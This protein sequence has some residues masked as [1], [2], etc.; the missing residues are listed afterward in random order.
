VTCA[1]LP[2]RVSRIGEHRRWAAKV[3]KGARV[4]TGDSRQSVDRAPH[5]SISS[6]PPPPPSLFLSL[7]RARARSFF[8][9]SVCSACSSSRHREAEH[10][11]LTK[12]ARGASVWACGEVRE[13][14]PVSARCLNV[15]KPRRAANNRL[16]RLRLRADGLDVAGTRGLS[17]RARSRSYGRVLWSR[18]YV[19]GLLWPW[20][21]RARER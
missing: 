16:I 15:D 19:R 21:P 5:C 9:G 14:L 7:S 10:A 2:L 11:R 13:C 3:F 12:S 20:R 17:G 8:F 18:G 6:C 1:R 4:R